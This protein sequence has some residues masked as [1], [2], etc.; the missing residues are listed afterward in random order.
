MTS[1][2]LEKLGDKLITKEDLLQEIKQDFRLVPVVIDGLS[3]SKATIRYGC[4]KV[5]MDLSETDPERLYK[6]MNTFVKLLENKHRIL[7]WN[8]TAIIANLT[9]VDTDKKFDAI[10]DEYYRLLDDE[11][12]VTV[13][14]TIANS[15]K[16]A[17]AKPY[18]IK[19]ITDKLLWTDKLATTPH[20]TEEC[21][22]VIAEKAIDSFSVF[23]DKMESKE[24]VIAFVSKH[25]NS[26][27][28]TLK[29]KAE[30]FLSRFG[31]K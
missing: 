18:L 22:R 6:Y 9:R 19:K 16:I 30:A 24:E 10:F 8:G 29:K 15:A 11:Y 13:A 1:E 21:K 14:N 2:L 23:F 5:L 7:V 20:L 4:G 31:Q 27:R 3:S 28:K 12:L 26:P 25:R 17:L